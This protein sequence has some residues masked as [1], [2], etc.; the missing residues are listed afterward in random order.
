MISEHAEQTFE[1][2]STTSRIG[3]GVEI[4]WH[5]VGVTTAPIEPFSDAVQVSWLQPTDWSYGTNDFSVKAKRRPVES[6]GEVSIPS[7]A[8]SPCVFEPPGEDETIVY[9]LE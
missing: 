2:N 4:P 5:S 8:V 3:G 6:D 9:W 1:R 7:R